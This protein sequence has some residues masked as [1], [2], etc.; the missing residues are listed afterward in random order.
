MVK[1]YKDSTENSHLFEN[2]SVISFLS[3]YCWAPVEEWLVVMAELLSTLCEDNIILIPKL[4][5]DSTKRR[6]KEEEND[7]PIYLMNLDAKNTSK[8]LAN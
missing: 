6:K 8:I 1:E 4:D 5:K 7:R 2:Y 3:I